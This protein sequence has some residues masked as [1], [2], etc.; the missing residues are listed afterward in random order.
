MICSICLR[1]PGRRATLAVINNDRLL[2]KT[3]RPSQHIP[4]SSRTSRVGERNISTSILRSV[5]QFSG[6]PICSVRFPKTLFGT[7]R[8]LRLT[9]SVGN[10]RVVI[11]LLECCQHF[12]SGGTYDDALRL[13]NYGSSTSIQGAG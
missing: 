2:L 1:T 13:C 7:S 5:T 10:I 12:W 6:L 8:F 9:K 4:T 11:S 3:Q